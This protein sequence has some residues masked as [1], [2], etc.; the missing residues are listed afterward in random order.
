MPWTLLGANGHTEY[1]EDGGGFLQKVCNVLWKGLS[2]KTRG[3]FNSGSINFS[4]KDYIVNIWHFVS[5]EG[6]D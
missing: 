2:E 6:F 4:I 3:W 5:H 1:G